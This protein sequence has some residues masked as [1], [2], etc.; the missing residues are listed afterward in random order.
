MTKK[1]RVENRKNAT[2]ADSL[3]I[4]KIYIRIRFFTKLVDPDPDHVYDYL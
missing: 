1:I 2:A 4:L 3:E